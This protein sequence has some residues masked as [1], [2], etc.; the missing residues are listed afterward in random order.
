MTEEL[1]LELE[2]ERRSLL[3]VVNQFSK[4]DGRMNTEI[5][6]LC[7]ELEMRANALYH[8]IYGK[9]GASLRL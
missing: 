9:P 3:E 8:L 7:H 6:A 2:L 1:M 5:D 4:G